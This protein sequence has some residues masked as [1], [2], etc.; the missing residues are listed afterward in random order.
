MRCSKCK[1]SWYAMMPEASN[2]LPDPD[3][4]LL[5]AAKAEVH[6]PVL[7]PRERKKSTH[8]VSVVLITLSLLAAATFGAI[9]LDLDYPI[10]H[11]SNI[12]ISKVKVRHEPSDHHDT[13]TPIVARYRL[14]NHSGKKLVLPTLL[15]KFYDAS[16]KLIDVAHVSIGEGDILPH[17]SLSLETKLRAPRAVHSVEIG[18]WT[19][20]DS[21]IMQPIQTT[22]AL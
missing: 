16:H 10:I 9:K 20:W 11:Q 6:L 1:H 17:K 8:I 2:R 15:V 22:E 14:T 21:F 3:T 19:I 4:T 7:M 5:S 18:M 12:S 13:S